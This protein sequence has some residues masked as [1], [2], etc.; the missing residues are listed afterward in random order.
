MVMKRLTSILV[1]SNEMKNKGI[2]LRMQRVRIL[3]SD[4]HVGF[5]ERSKRKKK[6]CDDVID[7][8]CSLDVMKRGEGHVRRAR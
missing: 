8:A 7:T 6:H 5:Q 1:V 4:L 2:S 3:L